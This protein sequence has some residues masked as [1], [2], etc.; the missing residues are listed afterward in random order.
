MFIAILLILIFFFLAYFFW[1]FNNIKRL[2]THSRI[3]KLSKGDL[4]YLSIGSGPTVL[5]CH[6]GA[7]G[8]D[9]IYMYQYLI[10]KGFRLICPSR[11]GYLRTNKSIGSSF[12]EQADILSELLDKLQIKDKVALITLSIG[13]PVALQFALRH[14]QKINCLVL[15]DAVSKEYGANESAKH[16]LL[17][18]LY[19]SKFGRELISFFMDIYGKIAPKSVFQAYLN[20]EST[21][22]KDDI[23]T[24]ANEVFSDPKELQKFRLFSQMII[25][26]GLRAEGV[27]N[28]MA[29][30][31]NLPRYHLEQITA[32]TLIT[33]SNKDKDVTFDH[34]VFSHQQI[35]GSQMYE[36]EG[37]GHMFWFGKEGRKIEEVVS[38]FIKKHNQ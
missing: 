36:F 38:E 8:Y 32:P 25:P 37:L 5:V 21:Y 15:Q 18:K 10:N 30:S 29:L 24:L 2:N 23:K 34:G 17:G 31:A 13:G 28:D 7:T 35:K 27:D 19:L 26:M 12:E 20:V 6:G 3:I 4:E 33:H 16:S 14:P 9:N 1:H 22:S 11:P